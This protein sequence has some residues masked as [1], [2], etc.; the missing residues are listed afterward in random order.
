MTGKRQKVYIESEII[1]I[2]MTNHLLSLMI[3]SFIPLGFSKS[4]KLSRYN[5]HT[6]MFYLCNQI[7]VIFFGKEFIDGI[8]RKRT[9]DTYEGRRWTM[10]IILLHWYSHWG[11]DSNG[12]ASTVHRKFEMLRPCY[13]HCKSCSRVHCVVSLQGRNLNPFFLSYHWFWYRTI[14]HHSSKIIMVWFENRG[15]FF[16]ISCYRS[17]ALE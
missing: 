14:V 13:V 12:A 10:F 4:A 6:I 17:T 16:R 5:V 1:G 15:F 9:H 8:I 11:R 3:F 2:R 7:V